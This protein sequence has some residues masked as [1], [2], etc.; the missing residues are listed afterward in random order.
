MRKPSKA[1][2]RILLLLTLLTL[3][4]AVAGCRTGGHGDAP[5]HIAG[6]GRGTSS[7]YDRPGY[8]TV[9][10]RG[11]LWVFESGSEALT[12]FQ[13]EGEPTRS[14]T[15]VGVGPH[16]MNVRSTNR[17]TIDEYLAADGR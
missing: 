4:A 17:R 3:T 11:Q 12:R 1:V 9:I 10:R 13:R 6:D 2:S 15:V 8:V 16:G 7:P 5:A 14:V